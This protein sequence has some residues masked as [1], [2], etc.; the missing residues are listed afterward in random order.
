[1]R[2][3][4]KPEYTYT[5]KTIRMLGI[6]NR[7]TLLFH[8]A[9]MIIILQIIVWYVSK[10]SGKS[11][12]I[13]FYLILVQFFLLLIYYTF[14]FFP[15][16]G[17]LST[18]LMFGIGTFLY[19][20]SIPLELTIR[21]MDFY[22]M[23]VYGSVL[24]DDVVKTKIIAMGLIAY[25]AFMLGYSLSK[26][27]NELKKDVRKIKCP[28]Y[29]FYL[30]LGLLSSGALIIFYRGELLSTGTSYSNA[31]LVRGSS[32]V[33]SFLTKFTILVFVLGGAF[34][35]LNQS[36]I[37]KASGYGLIFSCLIWGIYSFDKDPI[38]IAALGIMAPFLIN[39]SFN[40]YP[41]Y[42]VILVFMILILIIPLLSSIFSLYRG[43]AIQDVFAKIKDRGVYLRFDSAGPFVSII[44][45]LF[46]S[47]E[48]KLGLSYINSL[49][50]WIPKFIWENRP[51]DLSLSFA[52]I[53]IKG[54]MPG[55][56]LGFSL[57]AESYANFGPLGPLIQ[58]LFLGF[59][60]GLLW[61]GFFRFAL[62][63]QKQEIKI[64]YA[65]FGNYLLLTMHRAPV[66]GI[67]VQ[68]MQFAIPLLIL[69]R[70]FNNKRR[71]QSEDIMAS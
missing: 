3:H 50:S 57:L 12:V 62:V 40:R 41:L 14:Y 6:N 29:H 67:V 59:S 38:L 5:N 64:F 24:L 30:I 22:T 11:I 4:P 31:Y 26:Y 20:F 52:Q 46:E 44:Y 21:K 47:P 55:M 69:R 2:K 71:L 27:P 48:K 25:V 56:G 61:K 23:K 32:S 54:W 51:L 37:L 70:L 39:R 17:L 33:F 16:E 63:N 19:Y 43:N 65:V 10:I 53:N 42:K 36:K 34:L 1:M 66:S 58:Y 28:N 60:W 8:S 49:V 7:Q 68:I 18:P 15:I 9:I 13:L 35:I 45:C